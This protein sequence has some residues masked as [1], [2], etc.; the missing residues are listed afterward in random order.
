MIGLSVVNS[1]SNSRSVSPC[2]CPRPGEGRLDVMPDTRRSNTQGDAIRA[3]AGHVEVIAVARGSGDYHR[4]EFL[5]CFKV[6]R[7]RDRYGDLGR[8]EERRVGKEGGS[9]G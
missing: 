6:A 9:R 3:G 8:S 7:A 2:G 5:F 1:P 4:L